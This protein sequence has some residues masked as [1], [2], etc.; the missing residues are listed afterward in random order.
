MHTFNTTLNCTL[1]LY[2]STTTVISTLR[3]YT[4]V[5]LVMVGLVYKA[6]ARI[7]TLS[8]YG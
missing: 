6:Y 4:A 7:Y 5:D 2:R 1:M 8:C 3:C